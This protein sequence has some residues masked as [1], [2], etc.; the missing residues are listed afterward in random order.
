MPLRDSVVGLGR[1][2]FSFVPASLEIHPAST[3]FFSFAFVPPSLLP[4]SLP[5]C[6]TQWQTTFLLFCPPAVTDD[7]HH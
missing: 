5:R 7:A 3:L 4:D 6:L 1:G 2:M